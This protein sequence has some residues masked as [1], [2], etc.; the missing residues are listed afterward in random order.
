MVKKIQ[1]NL[2]TAEVDQKLALNSA[3]SN[4]ILSWKMHTKLILKFWMIKH[5]NLNSR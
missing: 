1:I 2:N 4:K 5:L 3:R